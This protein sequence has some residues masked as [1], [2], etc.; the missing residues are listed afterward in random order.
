MHQNSD[1]IS[2][3]PIRQRRRRRVDQF[4]LNTNDGS[5]V[6]KLPFQLFRFL[7]QQWPMALSPKRSPLS[8]G[9]FFQTYLT[10]AGTFARSLTNTWDTVC[11]CYSPVVLLPHH[12]PSRAATPAARRASLCLPQSTHPHF[13]AELV[14][15]L[16]SHTSPL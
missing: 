11:K 10:I 13:R 5:K 8:D 1:Q 16:H 3:F 14:L 4:K 12:H 6:L 2:L 7:S 9:H 15:G